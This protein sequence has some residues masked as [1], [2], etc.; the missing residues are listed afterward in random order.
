M[1]KQLGPGGATAV[2][3]VVADEKA[4]LTPAKKPPRAAPKWETETRERVK[5]AIKKFQKPL[6]DLVHRQ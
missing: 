4:T 3:V 1:A 6:A 2:P 5:A